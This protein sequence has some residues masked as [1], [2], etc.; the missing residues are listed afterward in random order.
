MIVDWI[1]KDADSGNNYTG[2]H[3]GSPGNRWLV[4]SMR[5]NY[6]TFAVGASNVATEFM[7]GNRDV[8][9]A[10]WKDRGSYIIVN[11]IKSTKN[12]YQNNSLGDEPNYTFYMGATNRDG[13][14]ILKPKL[15]IYSWKFY[16]DDILI[17]DFIPCYRKSDN[18]IGMYD[19]VNGIFYTNKGTGTFLKG[20][21]I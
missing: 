13:N 14:A 3:I 2:G 1:Y 6:Y 15:T 19:T 9:E 5:G 16:Q 20:N 10:Y 7:H 12:Q 8:I 21:D 4:G 11:G 17:R 18:V